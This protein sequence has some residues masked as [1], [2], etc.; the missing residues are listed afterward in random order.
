MEG[1]PARAREVLLPR[2]RERSPSRRRPR[3]RSR[4]GAP[5][6]GCSHRCCS[7]ST[8]C[9]CR[10]TGRARLMH[11][12]ASNSTSRRWRIGS[13]PAAATLMP[14]V[15]AIRAHVFA[16][17][18]I[19]ADDTTVPVLAKGKIRTGRLWTYVRDDRPFGGPDPPAAVFFYS[20]DRGGAASRAASGE[21]CRPDAGGRLRRLQQTLRGHAQAGADH[22]GGVLGAC[23]AQVL[24][25]GAAAQGADRDRG[26]AAHRCPVRH[27]ARDQR[28]GAARARRAC[29]RSAAGR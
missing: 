19:H 7:P 20:P 25:S 2:L 11:A 4:A 18:R 29:A 26:G 6:Q 13:A 23:A 3:I 1:D 9:T 28:A 21:L 17:E 16:A 5:G 12:R 14:L 8:A 24:R 22:R 15:E 10:S 27:R